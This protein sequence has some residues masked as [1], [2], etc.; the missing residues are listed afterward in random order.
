MHQRDFTHNL[1]DS[2]V[3][4]TRGDVFLIFHDNT[5]RVSHLKYDASAV[6]MEHL[7]VQIRRLFARD[8]PHELG[9]LI[10]LRETPHRYPV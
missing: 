4:G 9:H 7:A 10:R 5:W 2:V 6:E 1:E 8:K 3:G